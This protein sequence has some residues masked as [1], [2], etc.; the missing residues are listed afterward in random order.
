[1]AVANDW[2]ARQRLIDWISWTFMSWVVSKVPSG[3]SPFAPPAPSH[4][5]CQV[6]LAFNWYGVP[7]VARR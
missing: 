7:L 3:R 4:E 5:I 2:V 1:M 6:M